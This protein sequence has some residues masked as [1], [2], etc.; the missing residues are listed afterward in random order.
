MERRKLFSEE[1]R[2]RRK[3]FSAPKVESRDIKLFSDTAEEEAFQRTFSATEDEYELKLKEYSG[4]TIS[5]EEYTAAGF[6]DNE[7]E[8]GFA[9][10]DSE[11]NYTISPSAFVES[12]LFSK[13]TIS[14]TKTLE[15]DPTVMNEPREEVISRLS[16]SGRFSPKTIILLKKAHQIPVDKDSDGYITDSGISHDLPLEFG[17]RIMPKPEFEKIIQERY[18]DAPTDIM[19]LLKNKGIVKVDGENVEIIR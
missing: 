4:Q 7:I 16:E 1:P 3:L 6:G 15:L 2:E 18:E 12:R 19:D 5:A 11:G 13:I 17:G 14:V 9:S 8:K 10:K